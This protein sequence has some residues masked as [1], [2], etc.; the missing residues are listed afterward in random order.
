MIQLGIARLQPAEVRSTSSSSFTN[1]SIAHLLS[2]AAG[3]GQDGSAL[4]AVEVSARWWGAGLSSASVT[5]S[6]SS[7]RAVSPVVLDSIGRNLCR[8]GE[9]LHV[10]DVRAGRVTLTPCSNWTVLGD[11]DPASW[12]YLCTLNGPSTSTTKK[13][14]AASVV[15]TKYAPHP[16]RPWAGRSPM[17]M[18]TGTARAA[19]LLERATSAEFSFVQQQILS[20]RRNQNEY[21]MADTLTPD[22]I[23]KIVSSFSQHTGSG[24]LVI[25]GDLEP[26]RL[27]PSPPD[28][29]A[30]LRDRFENS[31][32]SMHGV[33]PA[34]V[35]EQGTGTAM[36]EAFRQVLHS[37]LKPLAGLVVEELQAKLDPDAEMSFSDLR[38][39]DI[40]GTS[41]ALGSLVKAGISPEAAAAIVGLDDDEV[42]A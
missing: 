30:N 41:R 37:L 26:R 9:S 10:I 36:R 1:Q 29:F 22:L 14:P 28:S 18:A 12:L 16:D 33:P 13:L 39:S 15:H 5:P 19:G 38:A 3:T 21:G 17:M 24:A 35:A 31:I 4:A 42:N 27:G 6:N 20:P 11:A 2:A 32:L 34:L 25:P 40:A 23:E 7:L 8:S